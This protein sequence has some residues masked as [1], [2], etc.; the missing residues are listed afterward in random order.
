MDEDKDAGATDAERVKCS[1]DDARRLV[2]PGCAM[3][4][5]WI[6]FAVVSTKAIGHVDKIYKEIVFRRSIWKTDE[7]W[8][9]DR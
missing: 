9:T 5:A 7:R 2:L 6:R 3:H 4:Q 8:F 1:F